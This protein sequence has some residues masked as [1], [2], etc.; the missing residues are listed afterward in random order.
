MITNYGVARPERAH[1]FFRAFYRLQTGLAAGSCNVRHHRI[2][3]RSSSTPSILRGSR[4]TA[5]HQSSIK[6]QRPLNNAFSVGHAAAVP[7]RRYP[8]LPFQDRGG[9]V[10][11]AEAEWLTAEDHQALQLLR[12]LTRCYVRYSRAEGVFALTIIGPQSRLQYANNCLNDVL[13]SYRQSGSTVSAKD[14]V[15]EQLDKQAARTGGDSGEAQ[16]KTTATEPD[17]HVESQLTMLLNDNDKQS[18][19]IRIRKNALLHLN[20]FSEFCRV[21]S[22]QGGLDSFNLV[23]NTGGTAT[24]VL[25]G[26]ENTRQRAI[27]AIEEDIRSE[28]ARNVTTISSDIAAI[29]VQIANQIPPGP[30]GLKL[31]LEPQPQEAQLRL[32]PLG[33]FLDRRDGRHWVHISGSRNEMQ[34]ARDRLGVLSQNLS[35]DTAKPVLEDESNV[36]CTENLKSLMRTVPSPVYLITT[37]QGSNNKSRQRM[38]AKVERCRGMTVS[39]FSTV[40]LEPSPIVSFNVKEPSRTLAAI[41]SSGRFYA[42]VLAANGS[43][44]ALANLFTLR[45]KNPAEPFVRANEIEGTSLIASQH[46]PRFTGKAVVGTMYCSVLY[47][48]NVTIGDHKVIFA[49]VEDVT[50]SNAD[51]EDSGIAYAHRAYMGAGSRITPQRLSTEAFDGAGLDQQVVYTDGPF[52]SNESAPGPSAVSKE[53]VYQSANPEVMSR[54]FEDMERVEREEDDDADMESEDAVNS[55]DVKSGDVISRA[56][57]QSENVTESDDSSDLSDNVAP[58]LPEEEAQQNGAAETDLAPGYKPDIPNNERR[59]SKSRG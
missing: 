1:Q 9:P 36:T 49:K 56:D 7:N 2:L 54:Y 39:S 32:L 11:D 48:K 57:R 12:K 22:D 13:Q 58:R 51:T 28:A 30:D 42:H 20:K 18:S 31:T 35:K 6:I 29:P 15:Q 34:Q 40:T 24:L 14:I 27:A 55:A 17:Y 23:K 33:E 41:L 3:A 50:T 5:P 43:G 45:H 8:S 46:G 59:F 21:S 47:L 25:Q 16:N 4:P 53:E 19:S 37:M 10:T 44:A 38:Q 26:H 52:D